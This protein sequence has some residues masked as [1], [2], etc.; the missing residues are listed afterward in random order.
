MCMPLFTPIASRPDNVHLLLNAALDILNNNPVL[1]LD[2]PSEAM[3]TVELVPAA[4]SLGEMTGL[5]I[6]LG[7]PYHASCEL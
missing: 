1:Q 5:W 7:I 2:S 6:A 4:L 3:R